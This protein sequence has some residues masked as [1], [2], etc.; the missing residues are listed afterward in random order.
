MDPNRGAAGSSTPTGMMPPSGN[1]L[2]S[3][4]GG[5]IGGGAGAGGGAGTGTTGVQSFSCDATASPDPGPSPLRVL[6]RSQ[7]L[8]TLRSLFGTL[9]DLSAALGTDTNATGAFGLVQPDIDVVQVEGFQSVAEAMATSVVSKADSL[10]A[11]APCAS[12]VDQR[13]CATT[14][15]KTFG[16]LA[17]RAPLTDAADIARHLAAYDVGAKISYAHGI[18]LLIRGM[19]QS[20]RFLYRV[21]LGTTER[22]GDNAVKLSP[23][24]V[25]ARLAYVV[26]DGPPDAALTAAAAAGQLTTADQLQTQLTRML[27]DP[28]GATFV[29]RFLEGWVQLASLDAVVKDQT[30]Y[31][32]W[33]GSGSTLEASE[34]G[35]AAAFFG[36]IV[37]NQNGSFDALLTSQQV[38]VNQDLASFYG[39]SAT[40]STFTPA[41]STTSSGLLTLP[42]L[43]AINAKPNESWPIYRGKFV[44]EAL[45]CQELPAP[46]PNIP[47][48]PDVS[49]GVSTRQR[50]SQHETDPSC[51]GCHSLMDP[52]GFGF[53]SF[54]AIGR[55]R[56][57]D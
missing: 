52:I 33:S 14:F 56:N 24:E 5:S 18:E 7:Y 49:P 35:Q 30:L 13:Q 43:L 47:K 6:S 45:L 15:V 3:G 38:F 44:R 57:T 41:T 46:P 51:S 9:P 8:N 28:K 21:E 4:S 23:S 36:D 40:G 25:A 34:K 26:W 22:I 10:A 54:D 39:A 48:P 11:I 32:Q 2:G 55:Y 53:E 31:P 37:G 42:A 29:Q 50:L 17:Y 1:G 19:L 20:P 16:A 27:V 12:G